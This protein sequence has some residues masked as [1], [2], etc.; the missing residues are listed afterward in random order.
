MIDIDKATEANARIWGAPRSRAG[1]PYPLDVLGLYCEFSWVVYTIQRYALGFTEGAADVTVRADGIWGDGTS[2]AWAKHTGTEPQPQPG[3]D[4]WERCTV[5]D[6]SH[7]QGDISWPVMYEAGA[8]GVIMKAT[9]G[10]GFVDPRLAEHWP[11]VRASTD[12]VRGSYHL[13]E[14]DDDPIAQAAHYVD[15]MADVGGWLVGDMRPALDIETSKIDEAMEKGASGS[16]VRD[17]ILTW[18]QEVESLTGEA[19]FLYISPRGI[20]HLG[21]DV[22]PLGEY[23]LWW[24]KRMSDPLNDPEVQAPWAEAALVQWSSTG[25]NGARFGVSSTEIDQNIY[26]GSAQLLRQAET[27]QEDWSR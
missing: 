8:R 27:F 11:A 2:A 23:P 26:R 19:P 5:T 10:L 4:P 9:Q 6:V 21:V 22:R 24:V 15:T 14:L 3:G 25:E 12:L 7:W 13:I 1:L 16:L 18:L 17:R 20:R